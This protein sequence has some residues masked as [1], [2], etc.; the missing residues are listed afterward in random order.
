MKELQKLGLFTEKNPSVVNFVD[1]LTFFR[2]NLRDIMSN[3]LF[4]HGYTTKYGI[5][6]FKKLILTIRWLII[7]VF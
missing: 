3:V 1:H 6:K 4:C 5:K 2:F 7:I